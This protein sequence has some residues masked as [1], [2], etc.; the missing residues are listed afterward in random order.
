MTETSPRVA[1]LGRPGP[2]R[3]HLRNALASLGGQITIEG[4]P[5]EMS[6]A[7]VAATEPTV[8][9]VSLDAAMEDEL[10]AW[11]ELFDTDGMN[12]I[13]DEAATT[14]QLDGW[15]LARWA[16]H[17]AA[18]IL[19]HDRTL[20]PAPEGA[21]QVH[22]AVDWIP[23]PGGPVSPAVQMDAERLE[24]Y[25]G[26]AVD[27]AGSVPVAD[28]PRT[29]DAGEHEGVEGEPSWSNDLTAIE[30]EELELDDEVAAL[31]AQ[32]DAHAGQDGIVRFD[33]FSGADDA[34]GSAPSEADAGLEMVD[35][36]PPALD[37][38]ADVADEA[39]G[40]AGSA[41]A[42]D[43]QAAEAETVPSP[44]LS[45]GRELSLVMDDA[46]VE[47]RQAEEGGTRA[48]AP[49]APAGM[50]FDQLAAAFELQDD[51]AAD[52]TDAATAAG[53]K[54]GVVV[55]L[56]GM[57]GPD[58]LR[59]LLSALPPRI[60]V[61]VLVWQQLNAGTHDRLASQ[62]AKTG[63]VETALAVAGESPQAGK[64]YILP[65]GVGLDCSE[66]MSFVEDA[67][68]PSSLLGSLAPLGDD[69]VVVA[70]SGTE[71][72]WLSDAENW[73]AQG[74]RLLAQSPATCFEASAC[75]SLVK[76]GVVDL[77]PAQLA[78]RALGKWHEEI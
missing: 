10:D 68:S 12:V 26:E 23:S 25:A 5:G 43:D 1:L 41:S 14:S 39:A 70:L 50:S 78:I 29:G 64:V 45:F 28:D 56:A 24:D 67:R 3:E 52:D 16:R 48:T 35:P 32:H 18:K 53:P 37:T 9:V 8:V 4:D 13:F 27:H 30:A 57:G 63:K 7:Q 58:A 75:E 46:E 69:A 62:L 17:L 51:D 77:A 15:D 60:P 76:Q 20:P 36:A 54:R 21:E 34:T 47:D 49:A 11:D 40:A 71:D 72:A 74:G 2:A 44:R 42:E 59:Q 38:G 31:M 22:G 33:G 66:G 55:L 73:A 19:G 65:P 61:P 6:P